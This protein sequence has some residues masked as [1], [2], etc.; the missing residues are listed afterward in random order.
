MPTPDQQSGTTV[1]SRLVAL[2]FTDIVDSTGIKSRVSTSANT[3]NLQRHNVLFEEAVTACREAKIIKHTGDGFFARFHTASDAARCALKFQRDLAREPWPSEPLRTRIGIHMGEIAM[4]RMLDRT[5]I[6]GSPADVA[7]RVMSLAL[8]DR[9]CSQNSPP[10]KHDGSCPA[11][12][13]A[14]RVTATTG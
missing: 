13:S 4:V 2:M 7:A 10:M 11:T 6:V 12:E 9:F 3:V 5:D 14:G 8:A 1:D